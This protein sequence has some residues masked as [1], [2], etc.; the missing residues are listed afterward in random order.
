[1][2]KEICKVGDM[3]LKPAIGSPICGDCGGTLQVLSE[4]GGRKARCCGNV[5]VIG[6]YTPGQM[7]D[8]NRA[9]VGS[10]DEWEKIT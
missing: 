3:N 10:T 6:Y 8:I 5:Y 1:M 7:D 9:R 4:E 2:Q